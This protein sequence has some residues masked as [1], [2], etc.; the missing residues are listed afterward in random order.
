MLLPVSH[1]SECYMEL[2]AV[3]MFIFII[4]YLIYQTYHT[5]W[6]K[7]ERLHLNIL[8]D[9]SHTVVTGCMLTWFLY[10]LASGFL[11][12]HFFTTY[13]LLSL[14]HFIGVKILQWQPVLTDFQKYFNW[15][16]SV[17]GFI[18]H[19]YHII[20]SSDNTVIIDLQRPSHL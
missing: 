20:L 19:L 4:V 17:Q 1:N 14:Y 13:Q 9:C 12:A 11:L 3:D 18:F 8:L 5:I 16:L 15:Y 2:F 7:Y 6:G 10:I